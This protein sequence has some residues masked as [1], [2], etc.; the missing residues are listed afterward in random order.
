[1]VA[2]IILLT[3][4][5]AY[6]LS[7]NLQQH[8][9]NPILKLA[10]TARA[11]SD[12]QDYSVR[13]IKEGDDELGQLTDSFNYMLMQ[14]EKQN[15]S[16]I[17]FNHQLEQS[18]AE[19]QDIMDYSV[20]VICTLDKQGNFVKVNAASKT[21]WDYEPA[22]L[23]GHNLK[24][25]V[26]EDNH[27]EITPVIEQIISGGLSANFENRIIRKDG[28]VLSMTWSARWKEKEK[29]IYCIARDATA[30]KEAEY[31][32]QKRAKELAYSNEELEQFAYIASHDL[33]EPLRM[34]SS[35]LT[36]LE[37]K[38][39]DQLDDKAR[40][41]IHFAV[42]GAVRMRRIILDLLE[43][44]RVGK[45][46]EQLELVDISEVVKQVVQFC[47]TTIEEKN[48]EVV[49]DNLPTVKTLRIPVQQMLQNL[50]GNA[51]KY[52]KEGVKP[53]VRITAEEEKDHWKIAV[54][55]NGI[56]IDPQFF[57][58]IF[59]AFQRL[60]NNS[61]YSGSGIGLAICKK[62]AE[63]YDIRLWVESELDKGSAFFFT[64]TKVQGKE[65]SSA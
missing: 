47:R 12:D 37:K 56:G 38:Y 57:D 9:A 43:Y 17:S 40:Q 29:L 59:I 1:M 55:D 42:D 2:L 16:I 28:K 33:Q 48:A 61:E 20:D 45:K 18:S 7:L 50:I 31:K 44:S 26:H 23:I 15:L 34:V 52:Q 5:L 63:K 53:V 27:A 13:A 30:I 10:E 22:E 24:N 35:F 58:K 3:S 19:L 14:I 46:K 39:K 49:W 54:I 32:L 21:L 64:I 51:L 65:V 8:I 41:Y 62:I 4:G 36:Q 25:L 6:F 60:H 11:I